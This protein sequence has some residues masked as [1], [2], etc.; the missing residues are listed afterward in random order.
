MNVITAPKSS[1][2]FSTRLSPTRLDETGAHF[3]TPGLLRSAR[4]DGARFPLSSPRHCEALLRRSNPVFLR[5]CREETI[6]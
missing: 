1:C 4:N 3:V 6:L 5:E 2:D